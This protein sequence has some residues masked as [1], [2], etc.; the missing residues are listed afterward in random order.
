[1]IVALAT[2]S[3]SAG[4]MAE[5]YGYKASG[6]TQVSDRKAGMATAEKYEEI[7]ITGVSKVTTF[8]VR[9]GVPIATVSLAGLDP[10]SDYGR[11]KMDSR[12]RHAARLVCGSTNT[13]FLGDQKI[14]TRNRQCAIKAIDSAWDQLNSGAV[15]YVDVSAHV[16]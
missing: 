8:S 15:A 4:I 14:R 12:L 6:S 3:F 9:D 10:Y 13:L 1:M 16:K 7:I 5:D 11:G 2:V